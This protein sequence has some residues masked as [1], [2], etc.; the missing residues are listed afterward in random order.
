MCTVLDVLSLL[1]PF[2][3]NDICFLFFHWAV[4]VING[5]LMCSFFLADIDVY[6]LFFK[7]FYVFYI[8]TVDVCLKQ[9]K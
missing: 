2:V 8:L 7:Q 5:L 4:D 9:K 6:F 3:F 1:R